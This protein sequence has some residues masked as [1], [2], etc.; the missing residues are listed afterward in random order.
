MSEGRASQAKAGCT[1]G[2]VRKI[3]LSSSM[4][5]ST[6]ATTSLGGCAA[7]KAGMSIEAVLA[8]AVPGGGAGMGEA[9][10]VYAPCMSMPPLPLPLEERR[11]RIS[12]EPICSTAQVSASA[13]HAGRD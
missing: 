5:S 6:E 1:L 2:A 13:S 8:K 7:S 9:P 3:V 4:S 11:T 10:L 12:K